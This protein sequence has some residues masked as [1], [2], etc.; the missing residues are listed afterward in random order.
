M[1]SN[2][3]GTPRE[4]LAANL[5]TPY[6][7]DEKYWSALLDAF[8][9]EIEELERVRAQVRAA[10]FV[11]TADAASLERL[12]TRFE[13]ERKTD[14][15][16]AEFRARV[17]VGLRSQLTSASLSETR[18]IISV[19]LDI[20]RGEIGLREPTDEAAVLEATID[21]SVLSGTDIERN[22]LD[23]LLNTVSA[24]GVLA[25]AI[26][27]SELNTGVTLAT[28]RDVEHTVVDDIRLSSPSINDLSTGG[29]QDGTNNSRTLD[30]GTV[31]V[32]AEDVQNN[33]VGPTVENID[34]VTDPVSH[35]TTATGGLSAATLNPLSTGGWDMT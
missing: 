11:D 9:A 32:V 28:G 29:W 14:E 17:K 21:G 31:N 6:S 7:A 12:A 15:P 4:R 33:I 3:E 1:S 19:L 27:A 26:S 8:A 18:D 16:L 20:D 13:L 23:E 30:V 35:T 2:L 5:K 34:V 22:T 10:K 25:R 24:A